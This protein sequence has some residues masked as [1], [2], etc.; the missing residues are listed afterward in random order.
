MNY[1]PQS[2]HYSVLK[3]LFPV[4][5]LQG[6]QDVTMDIEG[7]A[8]DRAELCGKTITIL[9]SGGLTD[10][11]FMAIFWLFKEKM[12]SFIKA[13]SLRSLIKCA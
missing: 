12:K 1:S 11:F 7:L 8:L 13:I 6:D 2:R 9:Q 5:F 10:H 3:K 4:S